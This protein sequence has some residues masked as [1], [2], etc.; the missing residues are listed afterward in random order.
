MGNTTTKSIITPK[1]VHQLIK[2]R[3]YTLLVF[4]RGQRCDYCGE[5]LSKLEGLRQQLVAV[6]C[7]L[8]GVSAQQNVYLQQIRNERHLQFPL[9]FDEE[10]LLAKQY[11]MYIAR[12][13]QPNY[14]RISQL[15]QRL[16]PDDKRIPQLTSTVCYRNG[17]VQPGVLI[18]DRKG[19]AIYRWLGQTAERTLFGAVGRV[20][21]RQLLSIIQHL[22][23]GQQKPQLK[24]CYQD[25][26]FNY[27]LTNTKGRELFRAHLNEEY[28]SELVDF[29]DAV[30]AFHDEITTA[31]EIYDLYI[32]VGSRKELNLRAEMR[33]TISNQTTLDPVPDT[34]FNEAADEVRVALKGS[35]QRFMM[36]PRSLSLVEAVPAWFD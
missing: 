23:N 20:E 4:F 36:T 2:A 16:K 22:A 10:H 25:Q 5:Y 15:F 33:T 30:E 19:E 18:V 31:Q 7:G 27:L 6:D 17:L 12:K 8:V 11:Q 34:I 13:G 24:R 26:L 35:L 3:N 14:N 1:R 21:P 32:Q 28:N 29:L 9:C